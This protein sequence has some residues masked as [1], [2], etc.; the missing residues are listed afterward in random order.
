M[1][2]NTGRRPVLPQ[3]LSGVKT[4]LEGTVTRVSANAFRININFTNG[5]TSI[6]AEF[7]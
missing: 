4:A 1:H 2:R 6:K 7:S 5:N 3:P